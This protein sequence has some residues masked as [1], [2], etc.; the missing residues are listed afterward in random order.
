MIRDADFPLRVLTLEPFV[1]DPPHDVVADQAEDHD[2]QEAEHDAELGAEVG[3]DH[4]DRIGGGFRIWIAK[5]EARWR[6]R[7]RC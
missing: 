7:S 6:G 2:A 5:V 3:G 1:D 4:P